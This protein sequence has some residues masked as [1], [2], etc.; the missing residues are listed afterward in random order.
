MTQDL[1]DS[2]LNNI[3]QELETS[4]EIS[5]NGTI[6]IYVNANPRLRSTITCTARTSVSNTHGQA[7]LKITASITHSGNTFQK[8][9]S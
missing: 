9:N 3:N 7:N 8:C 4:P 2:Y 6:Q 1:L 5:D